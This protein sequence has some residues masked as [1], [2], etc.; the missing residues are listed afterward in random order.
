MTESFFVRGFGRTISKDALPGPI[1]ASHTRFREQKGYTPPIFAVRFYLHEVTAGK[2]GRMTREWLQDIYEKA[3]N[4]FINKGN[5]S[6]NYPSGANLRSSSKIIEKALN[7]PNCDGCG[8]DCDFN[9]F[10]MK[11]IFKNERAELETGAGCNKVMVS[12]I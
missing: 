12:G 6:T 3:K 8:E 1:V 2:E 5:S 7:T 4:D 10:C 9:Y 11:E